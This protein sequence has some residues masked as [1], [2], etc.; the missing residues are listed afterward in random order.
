MRQ[1]VVFTENTL[2]SVPSDPWSG[3]NSGGVHGLLTL[4]SQPFPQPLLLLGAAKNKIFV[5]LN[6]F[7][8]SSLR[9]GT[10]SASANRIQEA[11]AE[12]SSWKCPSLPRAF[13]VFSCSV[14]AEQSENAKLVLLGL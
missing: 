5:L 12:I 6:T 8:L 11:V 1:L 2:T 14:L 13:V 9:A 10:F 4:L 7:G 3:T